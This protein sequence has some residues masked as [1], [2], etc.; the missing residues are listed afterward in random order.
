MKTWFIYLAVVVSGACV[1]AIEILGTRIL[2]PFYGVS[3]YLWSALI[4]VTLAALSLG[5]YLGGIWADRGPRLNR[6]S[7]LLALSGLW[8][9]FIP[10]LKHPVLAVAEPFGLRFAVLFAAF[11]LFFPP[12]TSLGMVSP[13][14]IRIK[15]TTI[16]TVGRTAGN[17]YAISTMA[18]VVSAILT[19]FFLIPSVGVSRLTFLVGIVLVA[20]ALIGLVSTRR[21]GVVVPSIVACLLLGAAG[22]RLAPVERWNSDMGLLTVEHSAYG[23]LRV[24]EKDGQRYLLIDGGVHTIVD[25]ETWESR[26]PYVD[27]V[28]IARL[29]TEKPG[30]VLIVGLGGGSVVKRYA[31]G[32]WQVDAVEIDPIVT[33]IANGYFGLRE[34]EARVHHMDGRQYLITHHETYDVIVMDAFGSSSI[35]FHLVTRES[36]GLAASRLAPGGILAMNIEAVGWEDIFVR[37]LAATLREHFDHVMALPIA[38]PPNVL[39]NLVLMASD[40]PLE[41]SEELPDPPDR[42]S[43]E[44]NR[45]HAWANSFEPNSDGVP[46]LTDDLNPVDLW[47]ERINLVARE[48]LHDYFGSQGVS[49]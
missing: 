16:D 48:D 10:W 5:Y 36:F 14:A 34:D 38:E 8:I 47:A 27:V 46:I 28:D 42:V 18:S 49:W 9:V 3:L 2:G 15:A 37:T 44:Y 29:C 40:R 1:L 20:T 12:L 19:G 7:L 21:P 31:R 43:A 6:F 17:L 23:E 4:G 35:P 30:R 33:K 41:L 24:V 25:P 11:V 22:N 45:V 32:G 26:F 13:Y 39:G